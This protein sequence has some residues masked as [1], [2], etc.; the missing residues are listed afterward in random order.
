MKVDY[1][2]QNFTQG[3]NFRS[4]DKNFP[5]LIVQFGSEKCMPCFAIKR[6][7]DAWIE[8][9]NNVKGIY[10]PIENFPK[11]A[12]NE[13]IFSVPTILVFVNG[14]PT[15]RES[16]YFSLENILS[17]IQRYIDFIKKS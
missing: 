1:T 16:G 7:I 2:M 6:K 4:I 10:V 14:M 5:I 15:I 11:V 8:L 9:H 17:K 3:F 13:G 12:A